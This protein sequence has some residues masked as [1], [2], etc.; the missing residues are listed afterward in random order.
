MKTCRLFTIVAALTLA[1]ASAVA[2]AQSEGPLG[3]QQAIVRRMIARLEA[4][5]NITSEQRAQMKAILK[6]EEPTILALA[7]QAKQ[8]REAMTALP[9][10]NEAEVRAIAQEYAVTNTNIVVERAKVRLELRAVLTEQQLQQ[11]EELKASL[12]GR[13]EE[14]LDT[15]IGQI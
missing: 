9:A 8:E 14:R 15:L 11:L 5:L 6:A 13:L 3:N 1:A 2:F 4:R 7:A 12:G 10:Y